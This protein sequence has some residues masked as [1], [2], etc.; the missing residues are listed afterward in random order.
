[1]RGGGDQSTLIV[2]EYIRL[3]GIPDEAH[4]YMVNGRTPLN[5][6]INRYKITTDKKSGKVNDPNTWFKN[7]EDLVSTIRRIV[8]LSVETIRIVRSLPDSIH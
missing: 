3:T 8:Y 5:W 7:P 2:N 6:L 4:E 1:M